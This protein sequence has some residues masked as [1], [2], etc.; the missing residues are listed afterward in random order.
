[1]S[2]EYAKAAFALGVV[3]ASSA[4]TYTI[5]AE[6]VVTTSNVFWSLDSA[7]VFVDLITFSLMWTNILL[8]ANALLH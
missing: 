7:V 8:E 5:L 3:E 1:M 2:A 4:E 6:K